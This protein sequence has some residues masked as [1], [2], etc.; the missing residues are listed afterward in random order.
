MNTYEEYKAYAL[1]LLEKAR[2]YYEVSVSNLS[3]SVNC[4]MDAL[5]NLSDAD[6]SIRVGRM[7]DYESKKGVL[8]SPDG[9][10][11]KD[12]ALRVELVYTAKKA[13][14]L[15]EYLVLNKQF[16]QV[17]FSQLLTASLQMGL[18]FFARDAAPFVSGITSIF[19]QICFFVYWSLVIE[20]PE[21]T[22][23]RATEDMAQKLKDSIK[24]AAPKGVEIDVKLN[25]Q[26]WNVFELIMWRPSSDLKY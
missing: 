19:L 2:G 10:L 1:R 20:T 6:N 9:I 23:E 18:S 24:I 7:S 8:C 21:Q 14:T 4:F 25:E 12:N 26:E 11:G 3:P 16:L 13:S 5:E 17:V 22:E 15:S